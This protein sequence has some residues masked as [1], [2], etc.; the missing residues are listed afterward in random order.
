MYGTLSDAS[1]NYARNSF[2]EFWRDERRRDMKII[3]RFTMS[4]F[5][6]KRFVRNS[7]WIFLLCAAMLGFSRIGAMAQDN[8]VIKIHTSVHWT[9]YAP[10]NIY[11]EHKADIANYYN[12]ADRAF[13]YITHAW[14][15]EPKIQ[16][17][18]LF[19]RPQTGGAFAA[20][21]IGEVHAVTGKQS[22]G[23]GVSYDAFYNVAN[24]IKG[25]WGYVLITHE[26]VN[27]LTGQIVSGG[28][29]VD[30]WADHKSPF[31]MMTAVQTEYALVPNVAI[32]HAQQLSGPHGQMFVHL[33]DQYGWALFRRAFSM[34]IKDGMNWDNIGQNPSAL[35]TN[36]VCAYLQMAAPESLAKYITPVVPDY[37]PSVVRQIIQAH[38]IISSANSDP[39]LKEAFLHGDYQKVLDSKK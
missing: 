14:G 17:Y 24:G 31:P 30:W 35:R 26:M 7:G 11:N 3:W 19:V 13:D 32:Y 39:S 28:W 20:G 38:K 8:T 18:S 23:I 1:P 33:K 22:P 9:W 16:H 6:R 27:L 37:S 4:R 21:D 25:F 10:Q 5:D 29:P 2:H 34:A 15:L 36:Y 12:Y